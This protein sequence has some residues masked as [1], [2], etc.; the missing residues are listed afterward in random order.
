LDHLT[1]PET[2]K[3]L[4]ETLKGFY[5]VIKASDEYLQFVLLTGVSKFSKVGVFSGLNNL[6]D[7]TMDAHYSTL[8]GYTQEEMEDYFAERISVLANQSGQETSAT[9]QSIKHWYNG[10]RFSPLST[11]VYNPFSTLLLFDKNSFTNYWFETGTPT[12]LLN[13][14]REKHYDL[15]TTESVEVGEAVFSSYE[16]DNLVV[17]ALLYQTGYLT[18]K[19]CEEDSDT[20]TRLYQLGYPN[21]EVKNSFLQY[22]LDDMGSVEKE[23]SEGYLGKL[24]KAF[25]T[26]DLDS[27]FRILRCFFAT[28]PYDLQINREKYYQTIFYL[29]FSLLGLRIEA[30]VK[31]NHGRI[32]AVLATHDRVY[33]FEFKLSGTKEEA[34]QQIKDNK[35]YEK[36]MT[37]PNSVPRSILLIGVEFNKVERNI[38]GWVVA[39]FR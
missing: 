29:V 39:V 36:Y 15:T 13:L 27:F 38:G 4:R 19:T 37:E 31:T 30:E 24:L 2:A 12:F 9:L 21:F 33:I 11:T 26:N 5:S 10:Y 16:I 14:I 18:I 28:I 7:I 32:D 8:L 6:N 35:Y 22:V 17:S 20:K 34:L 3:E 25:K 1:E 23:I